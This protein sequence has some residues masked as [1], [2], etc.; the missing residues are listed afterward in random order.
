MS[1][2]GAAFVL[3]YLLG[4]LLAFVKHPRWGLFTYMAAFYLHPPMRWWGETLPDLRWSLTAAIVTFLAMPRA[5]LP[6]N[7]TPWSS[8]TLTKI[9]VAYVVWMW[10]Q[11]AWANPEHLE[12]VILMTKYAILYYLIYRLIY[13]ESGLVDFALAHVAGCFYFSLLALA[14]ED[15]GR[16]EYVGGPGVNDSNT[17]GMHM[18]TGLIFAGTLI[19]SQRGWKRWVV[20]LTIPFITN[21]V[22]QTESRGAF[23]G[24]VCGGLIYYYFAPK[25]YRKY[26]G[27]LGVISVCILVAY[28]PTTYWERMNTIKAVRSEETIDG[29]SQTRV[30]LLKAQIEMFADHP[31]GL[32]ANTT[33]YLSR[34]YLD[35]KWLTAAAGMDVKIYGARSS[36]NTLMSV[37]V[38]QGIPGIILAILGG[39]SAFRIMRELKRFTV[40]IPLGVLGLFPAAICGSLITIFVSGLFTNY[41]KAEVQ[42]WTIAL[43]VSS[44]Q[45]FRR[46]AKADRLN[47][48]TQAAAN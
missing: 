4:L 12:G 5:K 37:L 32:G 16:L 26:I 10:V 38:D 13:D 22:L 24:A 46:T 2:T 9:F 42:L 41:L 25:V 17:L 29:S 18:A 30:E 40:Q 35:V 39:F 21:G 48:N 1:L 27:V 31:F 44:L 7:T 15:S 36:H 23:L 3:F 19:L 47:T 45:I 6:A 34:D 11:L 14:A 8:Q 20:M 33:A 43:L 28:A